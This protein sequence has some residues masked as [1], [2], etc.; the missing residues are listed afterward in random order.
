[1]NT[2]LQNIYQEVSSRYPHQKTFLQSVKEV[3]ESLNT[4]LKDK[5]LSSADYSL[6]ER[7][8]EP[9]RTISFKVLWVDDEGNKQ[10]N[11]GFRVQFNSAIGPYK[12]GLRFDPSVNEDVLKFL[13]FEQIFKNSLTGLSLGGGKGGSDFNPKGKSENEIRS[14]C[15]SFML[16]LHKHIGPKTDVPA[17]DIGVGAREIGYMYGMY[18][19]ISNRSEG[20][21]TGKDELF[22]GS[23]HRTEATGHGVFYFTESLTKANNIELKGLSAVISGSGNVAEYTAK[24]LIDYGVKVMTLSDRSGYLIKKDGL[25]QKDIETIVFERGKNK[26]LAQIAIA[27]ADYLEGKPWKAVPAEAYFPCATQNEVDEDD[28]KEMVKHAKF[29]VEGAN[30]P[31]TDLAT[32]VVRNNKIIYAPGK[33]AN[34]GGVTVSGIEMAQNAA[35]YAWT[36]DGVEMELKRIMDKIHNQCVKY[37]KNDEGFVDYVNGANIAGFI[38][39]FDAMKKLGW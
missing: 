31:L 18:K 32:T 33:A 38:R 4:Y 7:M 36:C 11:R 10:V 25:T 39:V 30:M 5:N 19:E 29:I 17:G 21:L 16:E 6:I 20:V 9:E 34:A 24:K 22:G 15:R 35:H 13:G 8:V 26:A 28:A 2:E 12:G 3:F 1:M 14:F 23:C 27:G 37:G